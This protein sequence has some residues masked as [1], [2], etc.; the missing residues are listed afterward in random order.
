ML[1]VMQFMLCPLLAPARGEGWMSLQQQTSLCGVKFWC[2]TPQ[3]HLVAAPL[4][5]AHAAL[6]RKWRATDGSDM[7]ACLPRGPRT[8]PVRASRLG[9]SVGYC[10]GTGVQASVFSPAFHRAAGDWMTLGRGFCALT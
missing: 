9:V 10:A 8:K 2:P 3:G 7:S 1:I 6:L 5:E 4:E